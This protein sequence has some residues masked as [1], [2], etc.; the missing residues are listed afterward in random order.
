MVPLATLRLGL[1]DN[2]SVLRTPKN[3]LKNILLVSFENVKGTVQ[4]FE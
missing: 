4:P 3:D 1:V 2:Y